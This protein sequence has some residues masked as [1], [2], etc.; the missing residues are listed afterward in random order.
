MQA[1]QGSPD[2]HKAIFVST[3]AWGVCS[4]L[5]AIPE[6]TVTTPTPCHS[7]AFFYEPNFNFLLTTISTF[8]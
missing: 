6:I 1:Q 3:K 8:Y 2:T 4:W 5:Y 7:S